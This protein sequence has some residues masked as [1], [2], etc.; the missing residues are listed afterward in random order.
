MDLK[1][2]IKHAGYRNINNHLNSANHCGTCTPSW[3]PDKHREIQ[4]SR[5]DL[6]NE[7]QHVINK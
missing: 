1:Y 6:T 4:P 5:K 7:R 3:N 2:P